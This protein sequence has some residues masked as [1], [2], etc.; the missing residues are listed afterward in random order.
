MKQNLVSFFLNYFFLN[1]YFL[2]LAETI[3][4]MKTLE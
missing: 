3:F 4:K 2:K 1:L